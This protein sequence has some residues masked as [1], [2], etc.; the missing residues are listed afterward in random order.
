MSRVVYVRVP[1]RCA[2]LCLLVVGT[3]LAACSSSKSSSGS[4]GVSAAS[5]AVTPTSAAPASAASAPSST[6]TGATVPGVTSDSITIGVSAPY[7][8]AYGALIKQS[9]TNGFDVWVSQVNAQGGI[10][11]RKIILKD[12]DN[13]GTTDGAVS[14]CKQAQTNDTFLTVIINSQNSGNAEPDCLDQHAIPAVYAVST[15]PINPAWKYIRVVNEMPDTGAVLAAFVKNEVKVG[16][17]KLGALYIPAEANWIAT[18]QSGL[19]NLGLTL[20]DKELIETG[21]ASFT[22]QLEHLKQA[23]VQNVAIFAGVELI[24][25]LR[26]A[27][28]LGYAPSW[29]GTGWAVDD[30]SQILKSQLTGVTSIQETAT[31]DSP[32][33]QQYLATATQVGDKGANRDSFGTYGYGLIVGKV[34]EEAGMNPTR[35]SLE[36]GFNQI[37]DFDTQVIGPVTWTG[38]AIVGAPAQFPSVCC[39]ADWTWKGLGPASTTF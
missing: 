4:A 24:G 21:G 11:G 33:Y 12:V 7:S 26:D 22:A 31:V 3:L 28:A 9:I 14:A 32:V 2:A 27:K 16:S 19:Q 10:Y 29:T 37:S 30:Y 6:G 20:T 18:Y 13:V 36:A 1:I 8:S 25:I 38:G 23:G 35:A 15:Y 39:N 5:A 34:L 17:E